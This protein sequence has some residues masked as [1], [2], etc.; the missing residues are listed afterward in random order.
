MLYFQNWNLVFAGN[1]PDGM[2]FDYDTTASEETF[3]EAEMSVLRSGAVFI[4]GKVVVPDAVLTDRKKQ[5]A[6]KLILSRYSI[7]DQMNINS[8]GTPE[9]KGAMSAYILGILTEYRTKWKDADFS[10]F[11]S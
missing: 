8:F 10:A 3:S 11:S 7:T 4:D 1:V 9:Q 2:E 6:Q 5:E